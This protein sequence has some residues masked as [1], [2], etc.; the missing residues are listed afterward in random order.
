M[1]SRYPGE[2]WA[3]AAIKPFQLGFVYELKIFPLLSVCFVDHTIRK[4]Y[5]VYLKRGYDLKRIFDL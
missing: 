1:V 4:S 5:V 2:A 3:N